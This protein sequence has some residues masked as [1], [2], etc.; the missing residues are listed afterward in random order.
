[1]T[2]PVLQTYTFTHF[3]SKIQKKKKKHKQMYMLLKYNICHDWNLFSVLIT[4]LEFACFKQLLIYVLYVIIII[5][6]Y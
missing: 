3:L 4:S 1:M 5:V 2:K 6:S